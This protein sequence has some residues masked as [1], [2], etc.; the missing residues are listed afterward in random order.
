MNNETTAGNKPK[1]SRCIKTDIFYSEIP[2]TI[3]I[4][5]RN[6]QKYPIVL[7][8]GAGGNKNQFRFI[9]PYL[10]EQGV[11]LYIPTLSAKRENRNGL[12]LSSA[13]IWDY[14]EDINEIMDG[15]NVPCVVIAHSISA[16]GIYEYINRFGHKSKIKA[17]LLVSPMPHKGFKLP[18]HVRLKIICN[19]Q[20]VKAMLTSRCFSF[21]ESHCRNFLFS[22]INKPF[23]DILINKISKASG[24]ALKQILLNKVPNMEEKRLWEKVPH[25][26]VFSG[27]NDRLIPL[28]L[29]RRIAESLQVEFFPLQSHHQ[30]FL[31]SNHEKNIGE[32]R[33]WLVSVD[34][35]T[36]NN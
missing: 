9:I 23:Q 13:S 12:M 16:L 8:H 31:E 6:T 30:P 28:S 24:Y 34:A 1:S 18:L 25:T 7:L 33:D 10:L 27:T 4:P 3:Y 15:L 22:G 17:L 5:E 11:K 36:H 20:Y 35:L 14:G 26:A 19:L 29:S 2:V 21:S 32:M